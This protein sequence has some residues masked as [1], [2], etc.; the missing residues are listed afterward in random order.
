[1]KLVWSLLVV[2]GLAGQSLKW[3]KQLLSVEDKKKYNDFY[4]LDRGAGACLVYVRNDGKGVHLE[5]PDGIIYSDG[6][7]ARKTIVDISKN[8]DG[9][10]TVKQENFKQVAGPPREQWEKDNKPTSGRLSVAVYDNFSSM[11]ADQARKLPGLVKSLFFGN[12]GLGIKPK[13]K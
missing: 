1:M 9:K 6:A 7:T 10:V 12:Y 13:Q 4:Y 8:S 11:C 2:A 5:A 3:E